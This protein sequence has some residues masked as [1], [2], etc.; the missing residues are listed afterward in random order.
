V[1]DTEVDGAGV[2][3]STN[4]EAAE[5]GFYKCSMLA[6]ANSTEGGVFYY[7]ALSD[8]A[9][10]SDT[11]NPIYVGDNSSGVYVW[12]PKLVDV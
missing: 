12:R 2:I 1:T 4:I 3:T 7:I 5:Y 11:P 8:S 6:Q 9:T 10:H